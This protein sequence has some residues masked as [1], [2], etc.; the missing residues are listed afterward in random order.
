M[1]TTVQLHVIET[2]SA[3]VESTSRPRKLATLSRG[4]QAIGESCVDES[5]VRGFDLGGHFLMGCPPFGRID[6]DSLSVADERLSF[7]IGLAAEAVRPSR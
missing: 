6:P 3:S 4:K 2:S 1:T 5:G 7:S